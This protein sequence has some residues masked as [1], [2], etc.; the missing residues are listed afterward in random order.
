MHLD[1]FLIDHYCVIEPMW[2]ADGLFL[3]FGWP[4]EDS[5]LLIGSHHAG[6]DL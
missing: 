4:L 1:S 6:G 3:L 2:H 5:D